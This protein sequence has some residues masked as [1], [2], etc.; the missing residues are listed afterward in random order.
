LVRDLVDLMRPWFGG[1]VR[2]PEPMEPNRE[3]PV[4]VTLDDFDDPADV[5]DALAWGRFIAGVEP[6]ARTRHLSRLRD[7]A[8]LLP[9]GVGASR[10]VVSG[11][12][13]THLACGPGWTLRAVRWADRSGRIT[14]SAITDAVAKQVLDAA[15]ADAVEPP[16]DVDETVTVTFWHQ[17]RC[18]QHSVDREVAVEPWAGIRH[19]YSAPAATA[20]DA[21]M[22]IEPSRLSGRMLLLH[23]PP[24]TGK[25]TVLRALGH[26]WR[27]WCRLEV[28]ID[29]EKLLGDSAY[30]TDF[31]V[32]DRGSNDDEPSWRLV[33]LEDCDELI[34]AEAKQGVG[35]ALARLLN[36]TD[37]FLGQ[38]MSILLALT[39]NEPIHHLHPAIVRP[40]RCLA[41]IAVGRLSRREAIAW[42]GCADGVGPD[43]ATLAELIARRGRLPKVECAAPIAPVGQYL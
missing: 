3:P 32:G 29:P 31:V 16:G 13:R 34:R 39:T 28:V 25:T 40:G 36:L 33:V 5:I 22:A 41:D 7:D 20:L 11:G 21:V 15:S 14:V 19:N 23:G 1:T 17:V 27:S 12:Y 35:Q 18:G 9:P 30:L 8:P 24:G 38:G 6:A 2:T 37:G 4:V 43:G 10:T 26:A 42:L